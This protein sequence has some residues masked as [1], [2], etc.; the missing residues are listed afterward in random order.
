MPNKT[1]RK[2]EKQVIQSLTKSCENIKTQVPGF[3]W[4]THNVDYG[5]FPQSLI[6]TCVFDNI[7]SYQTAC[8]ASHQYLIGDIIRS[9]LSAIDIELKNIHKHLCFDTEEACAVESA[10]NWNR[11]L[12]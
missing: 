3:E 5:R 11:R 6:I 7:A 12:F 10:G 1:A 4:L 2:L 9:D 8:T